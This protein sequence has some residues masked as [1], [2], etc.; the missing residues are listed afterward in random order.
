MRRPPPN[1]GLTCAIDY[2]YLM[3]GKESSVIRISEGIGRDLPGR[4]V[5]SK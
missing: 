3:V 1:E 5:S 2:D 4:L